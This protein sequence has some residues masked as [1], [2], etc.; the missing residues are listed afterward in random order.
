MLEVRSK[1]GVQI[2]C[3]RT[4]SGPA[5]LLIHGSGSDSSSWRPAISELESHF[6]LLSMDRRGHG[7]SGDADTYCIENEWADIAACIEAFADGPCDVLGHS[8]GGL[9]ALGAARAGAPIRRLA[10]FEPPIPTY[11]EAYHPDNLIETMRTALA[12]GDCDKAAEAFVTG[13]FRSGADDF[14]ETK[15]LAMWLQVA[16]NANILL[17]ELETVGQFKLGAED[18]GDWAIPTLLMVGS[19]SAPQY[20]ATIEALRAILP[21][22]RIAE[23]QGQ[24]HS[25]VRTAP[26]LFA[27]AVRK[28]LQSSGEKTMSPSRLRGT[29]KRPV[30]AV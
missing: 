12:G 16:K 24:Q 15:K 14:P 22:S 3:Q 11:P 28:F 23:L 18:Y 26:T 10:L 1:D 30:R 6:T 29:A 13:V 7:K 4:G 27:T 20:G 5:L 17:R 9:C 19:E 8:Y 25:A 21:G 2:S